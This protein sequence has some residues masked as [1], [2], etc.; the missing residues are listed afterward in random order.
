MTY[1]ISIIYATYCIIIC[2]TG[3]CYRSIL[4]CSS[5]AKH[6]VESFSAD[7]DVQ[8]PDLKKVLCVY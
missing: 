6:D 4:L 5:T 3:V 7:H 2:Y 8:S 1:C